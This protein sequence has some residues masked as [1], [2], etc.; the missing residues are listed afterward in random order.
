[1]HDPNPDWATRMTELEGELR[2]WRTACPKATLTQ[3]EAELDRRLQAARAELLSEVAQGVSG[4]DGHCPQCGGLL[5]GRGSRERTLTTHGDEPLPL[6]RH[7]RYC[8]AC[9]SGLPPWMRCWGCCP[10]AC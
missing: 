3:I 10:A 6:T 4:E 8:P 5:V 9:E 2:A 7:Y 1:M